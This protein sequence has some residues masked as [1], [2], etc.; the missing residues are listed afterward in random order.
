MTALR[1]SAMPKKE[2]RPNPSKAQ[3]AGQQ[4]LMQDIQR[5]KHIVRDQLYPVLHEHATTVHDASGKAEVFKTLVLMA[6]QKPF[7]EATVGEL[8]FTDAMSSEDEAGKIVFSAFL[9]AFKD[10]KIADTLAVLQELDGGLQ[11]YF[12]GERRKREFKTITIEDLIGN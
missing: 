4:K 5:R 10:V 8:D 2:K 3:L 11:S 6:M 12:Q 1:K 9:D 7:R